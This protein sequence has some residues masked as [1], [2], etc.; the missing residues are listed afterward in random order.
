MPNDTIE[1]IID[2]EG[3]DTYQPKAALIVFEKEGHG[4][5]CFIELREIRRDGSMAAARPVSSRFVQDLLAG[6][7]REY[8]SIPHGPIPGNL[9]YCDTRRGHEAYIWY[10]PPCRRNRFFAESLHMEDGTY[11]V[12]GTLYAVRDGVLSVYCFAGRKPALDAPL[13]GVPYFNVY[14]DGKVCMGSARPQIPDTD[15]LSYEDVLL[16][17]EGAFWNSVDVHTNGSPSTKANLIETIKKYRDK[18]FDAS[19]LETRKDG[20]TVNALIARSR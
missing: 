7:S 5:D 15:R 16:A 3:C 4:A 1:Q 11:H 17:W 18:P 19:E 8:R 14:A 6:F 13:L 9:L 12:P 2:I 20:L 10:N